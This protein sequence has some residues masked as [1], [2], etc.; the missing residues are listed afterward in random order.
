MPSHWL[1]RKR[2]PGFI[3]L[4]LHF[5]L[6]LLLACSSLFSLALLFQKEGCPLLSKL[7]FCFLFILQNPSLY[8]Q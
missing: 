4:E 7:I 8:S 3:S 5:S 2:L 1:L 6:Q